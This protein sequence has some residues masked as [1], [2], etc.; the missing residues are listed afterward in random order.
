MTDTE[1]R[2]TCPYCG[3]GCGVLAR[4]E[5]DG[6]V[7]VRGDPEHPAN[8]GRL[9]S[10]GSALGDTFDSSSRLLHP[11]VHGQR[12]TWDAALGLVAGR[13]R[14]VLDRHG[15]EAVAFYVSGQLLTEDYY[16]ANKLMKGFIGGANI[17]TNSRLCM[18]SAVAG[19]KRAFGTDTVPGCYED[20]E[21]AKLV[22]LVGSN[23]AWCHPVLYQRLV[24]AKKDHPELRVVLIDPRR[25]ASADIADAHLALRPGTDAVLF[26]GLLVHLADHDETNPLFVEPHTEGLDDALACARAGSPDIEGVARACGL[27]PAQVAEFF[28]LFARTERV[29][30]LF[31]QGVNQSSSGTDKVNSIINCHLLTGRIGRPGMGPFSL[32]GQPNAMGGREVGGLA[33]QLAAHFELDFPA[34]RALVQEFWRAPTIASRPG[35]KAVDLF[36][37]VE[38]GGIKV[39]WIMATNPAVSLPDS[40]QARRAL[41]Q[42]ELVI[43]SDCVRHTDTTRYA[44]VLLPALGWGE[45]DGT[46]TNSER[47]ISR[48]RAFLP[49]PGEARPDWWMVCEVAKRLGFER[50]F[51]Y[52]NA[53]A[54]FREHAALSAV[55]NGGTRAFDLS[56]LADLSDEA[57]AALAPLQWPV[58]ARQSKGTARLFGDGGF[59]TASGR[60]RFVAV[61]PRPPAHAT[62]KDF[63]L[64]L[65]TGRVRDHWHTLT[66][67][68]LSARLSAHTHEPYV[69]IHPDD[70][71]PLGLAEGTLARIE[72]VWGRASARVRVADS[73]R[74][75]TVFAPMHWNDQFT[76][77]GC[78]GRAVN[79]ATDPISGEPE[80]K[81]TPVRLVPQKPAW[82]GFLL[83]RRRLNAGGASY[84]AMARGRGLWRYELAGDDLPQ[85]WAAAARAA[86]CAHDEKV[87]WIE[88]FDTAVRRYRAARLTDGQLES[89]IFIGPDPQ[90]PPREWLAG[91]FA[92]NQ[93]DAPTRAGLLT[94]TPPKGAPDA[95][96]PICACFGVGE[97]TLRAAIAG[98][99]ASVEA[100]GARLKAGT[101][102]GSCV[103]EI[104]ALL[105]RD[106]GAKGESRIAFRR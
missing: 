70:A 106:G 4:V 91:L 99:C 90:L 51:D 40:A 50:A 86:L 84:W 92:L 66:R 25:T 104:K 43:V 56:G 98:G 33:N 22:V 35:L 82:Y 68:G 52:A 34:H 105:A 21:R 19:H 101:H 15:P 39:L 60:G 6:G 12:A 42:C 30:T 64:A 44:H 100:I 58:T 81:H 27:G 71:R 69:E 48:Q 26:N 14:A 87:E 45:K 46:V 2:T 28:A 88:Y 49:P 16:V 3:V 5:S 62:N 23:A 61:T 10:K 32:T 65:N 20:I 93:L 13:L 54:I 75:G 31:S 89:C 85:D 67:T 78:I 29:V 17:D 73:V 77:A 72:S 74:P 37:A 7:S 63:P 9:C 102:C 55:A 97:K 53:A 96:R 76:N 11:L 79:P 18:A 57:Y 47:R 95:G 59:F 1:T 80:F 103:P 83:S 36:R 38:A 24:Q 41:E 8:L 94:G